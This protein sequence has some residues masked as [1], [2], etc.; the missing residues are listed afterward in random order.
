MTGVASL[1]ITVPERLAEGAVL[2]SRYV[3]E[4]LLGDG[5]MGAVYR[6][7]HIKVGR[8]FAVKVLHRALTANAKMLRRFE[9]EAELAGRLS[10]PNL[11]GVVD[12]GAT[13]SGLHYLV[14]EFAPGETLAR[15]IDQA[16]MDEMRVIELAR[17][18]C[19]GLQAAHDA[20]LVHRD[21]KPENVIVEMDQSGREIPRIV[22][23]GVAILR[24]P[25]AP[26]TDDRGRLTTKGVVIGTPHYMAPEQ[27]LGAT[28]DHRVDLFALGL[29]CY[30]MLTGKLPFEGD[31]VDVAR[32]N[33]SA[34]TP[35]MGMRVPTVIVDPVLEA[36]VG[37]LLEKHPADRPPSASATRDLLDLFVRDRLAAAEAVGFAMMT[38]PPPAPV[39]APP[40]VIEAPEPPAVPST[41]ARREQ[42]RTTEVPE[43]RR[44]RRIISIIALAAL[45]LLL[46][47]WI[48]TRSHAKATG[49]APAPEVTLPMVPVDDV[50]VG[51]RD[52]QAHDLAPPPVATTEPH[53]IAP[54]RDRSDAASCARTRRHEAS[55]GNARRR[56]SARSARRRWP[57]STAPSVASSRR[58]RRP[59]VTRPHSGCGHAIAGSG[60]TSG[61]ARRSAARRSRPASTSCAA[62]SR[63]R[64]ASS[65]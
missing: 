7:R 40:P 27:A 41:R 51:V 2:A 4:T 43:R 45:A 25:T 5:A 20:G 16:P 3:I 46:V 26:E 61:S 56:T 21:F 11:I 37:K 13:D 50:P 34:D 6:A 22:D 8:K 14:M 15:L 38:P 36:I 35:P 64:A 58:S 28:L 54:D 18:L 17:Q 10:H 33:M 12:V 30:E 57:R 65:R 55:A 42:E 62:T 63:S 24:D 39:V 52:H 32:A 23:F 1:K 59:R 60:S 31:G 44:A 19:D 48:G 9:R 47:V 49:V 29:I 53:A